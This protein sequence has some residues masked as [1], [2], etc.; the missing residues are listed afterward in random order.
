MISECMI[1]AAV[2]ESQVGGSK[3]YVKN[4]HLLIS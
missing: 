3:Q 4:S 1:F 2:A